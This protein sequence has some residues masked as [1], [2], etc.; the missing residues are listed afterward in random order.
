[1]PS[2]SDEAIVL[3]RHPYRERDLIV[4]MLTRGQGLVR[5]VARRAR[6]G[7]APLTSALEPLALVRV[8]FF[9]RP[10]KELVSLDEA[11]LVRTAFPLAAEPAAWAAGQLVAEL[12]LVY[13]P[14]GQANETSFRL[15]NHCVEHLL[16]G[17]DPFVVAAYAELWFI[18]LSGIL[19]DL[20]RCAVCGEA[21][22]GPS[23][24]FDGKEGGFVCLLHRGGGADVLRISGEAVRWL[25]RARRLPLDAI[26]EAPPADAA[27]WL[28][29]VQRRF[30]D[31]ELVSRRYLRLLVS[32]P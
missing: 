8:G 20:G 18:K 26:N 7:R 32:S 5:G 30:S 21:L 11:V 12:A 4:A 27:Q 29:E 19:P 31:R 23:R 25:E 28:A 2:R 13:C 14:P 9:E 3:S 6:G 15:V 17:G 10:R 16:A 22:S 1:M 24:V